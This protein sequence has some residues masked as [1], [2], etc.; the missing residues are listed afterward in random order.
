[1]ELGNMLLLKEDLIEML[2]KGFVI[3]DENDIK[4]RVQLCN[5]IEDIKRCK[6]KEIELDIS[7]RI[8]KESKV[9]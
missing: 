9:K 2:N 6:D 1:M 5:I 7:E 8:R 3:L 4:R